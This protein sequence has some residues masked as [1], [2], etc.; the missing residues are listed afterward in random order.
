M[1]PAIIA[2]RGASADAPENTLAAFRLAW[3]QGADA[4]E[5]DLRPTRDGRLAVFHDADLG[6]ITGTRGAVEALDAGALRRLDAGSWKHARWR[7][8]PIPLLEDALA[9]VPPNGRVFL[10]LKGGEAMVQELRR[11]L[12]ESRLAPAQVVVIA[13]DR[14]VL[15][16]SRR[17]LPSVE[18][19]WIIGRP[20]AQPSFEELLRNAAGDGLDALDFCAAWP[21]DAGR[22]A[23]AH[24]AGLR[25]YVW[26]VDDPEL[27]RR[28]AE[29]GV[30]GITTNAPALVRAALP[31]SEHDPR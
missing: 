10:E 25:I 23:R 21:L 18:H 6:R 7:G 28:L 3:E 5:M 31:R 2:H 27:S 15:L 26:T 19:G 11:A 24:R 9:L 13:F 20:E 30:D 1:R 12:E 4:V 17:L 8:E 29:A 14:A 16:A 22:V